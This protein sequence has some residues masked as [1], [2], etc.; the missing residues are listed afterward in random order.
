M[1]L[2]AV[3]RIIL[4]AIALVVG[5]APAGMGVAAGEGGV[6]CPAVST[7]AGAGHPHAVTGH[8]G[9]HE[10]DAAGDH[11][12]ADLAGPAHSCPCAFCA[13]M[14]AAPPLPVIGWSV[15]LPGPRAVAALAGRPTAPELPPPRT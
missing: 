11:R 1:P 10:G 14:A 15:T 7:D 5:L 13:P 2:A 6:H 3:V 12:R 8:A 9:H 4:L